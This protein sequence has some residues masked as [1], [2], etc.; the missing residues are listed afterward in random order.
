M[1]QLILTVPPATP[2]P[3]PSLSA[4]NIT[5]PLVTVMAAET[6]TS[7]PAIAVRSPVVIAVAA[8][9]L[10]LPA[11]LNLRLPVVVVV[12]ASRLIS[13]PEFATRL[14]LVPVMACL[15]F[16]SRS[17][18]NVRVVLAVQTTASLTLISPF[19]MPPAPRFLVVT[20]TLVPPNASFRSLTFTL[21][22]PTPEFGAK[23]PAL[24]VAFVIAAFDIETSAGSS[25]QSP[26]LPFG[27][28]ALTRIP[29]TSSIW[30]EVS[31][32]PPSPPCAPPR[33]VMLP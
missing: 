24:G 3:V 6:F 29:A 14:P 26:L 17:A 10:T 18:C 19:P 2:G 15:I 33:A 9:R 30:P 12:A 22:M 31:I 13:R 21:A 28:L 32:K 8:F 23:T 1:P 16:M 4:R 27:A 5:L 11:A 20:V 25:S 7:F